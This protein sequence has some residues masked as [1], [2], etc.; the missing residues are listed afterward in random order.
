M[1]LVVPFLVFSGL[2]S[3]NTRSPGVSSVCEYTVYVLYNSP[4]HGFLLIY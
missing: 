2:A 4:I 1:Q 3:R